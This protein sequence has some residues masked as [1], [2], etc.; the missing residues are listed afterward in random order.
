MVLRQ[1]YE[2]HNEA[3]KLIKDKPE[4]KQLIIQ[5]TCAKVQSLLDNWKKQN[6]N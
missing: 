2:L 5:E 4:D 3:I 6:N 1:V